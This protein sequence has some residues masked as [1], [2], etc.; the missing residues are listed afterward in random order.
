MA[1]GRQVRLFRPMTRTG[2]RGDSPTCGCIA[3]SISGRKV[4]RGSIASSAGASATLRQPPHRTQ[5]P[6]SPSYVRR[7]NHRGA[8]A[9]APASCTP[10]PPKCLNGP[11]LA[12]EPCMETQTKQGALPLYWPLRQLCVGSLTSRTHLVSYGRQLLATRHLIQ[13][14]PHEARSMRDSS[15]SSRMVIPSV[16]KTSLTK[17]KAAVSPTTVSRSRNRRLPLS[18]LIG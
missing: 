9:S 13:E 4:P 14:L 2:A 10:C 3:I 16:S 18:G 11:R 12:S 1:T 15:T 17:S 8:A 5:T 7:R 6:P